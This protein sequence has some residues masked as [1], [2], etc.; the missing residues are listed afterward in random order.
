MFLAV[1]L[2]TEN[3]ISRDRPNER[4]M[5]RIEKGKTFFVKRLEKSSITFLRLFREL[6]VSYFAYTMAYW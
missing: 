1:H 6:L 4:R 3:L 5:E 2:K